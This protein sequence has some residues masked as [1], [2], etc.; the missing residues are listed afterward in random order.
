MS[1]QLSIEKY[2]KPRKIKYHKIATT[3]STVSAAWNKNEPVIKRLQNI[4]ASWNDFPA[5]DPLH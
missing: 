5:P 4:P 3:L 1:Q 2:F